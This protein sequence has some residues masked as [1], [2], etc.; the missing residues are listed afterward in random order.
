MELGLI[1]EIS[2]NNFREILDKPVS[3]L[4][5]FSDWEMDCLIALPVL[6]SLAEE[7]EDKIFFGNVNVDEEE[8]IKENFE[9]EKLPC[10]IVFK[11]GRE[12]ERVY[13]CVCEEILR[14]RIGYLF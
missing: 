8:E 5:F 6:E 4:N 14:E 13:N 12:V 2:G 10:V 3:V 1:K 11:N 9:I 7:F